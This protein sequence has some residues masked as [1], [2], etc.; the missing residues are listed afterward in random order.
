MYNNLLYAHTYIYIHMITHA[1]TYIIMYICNVQYIQRKN[2]APRMSYGIS[3]RGIQISIQILLKP[4]FKGR[5]TRDA[6]KVAWTSYAKVS[7]GLSYSF[8]RGKLRTFSLLLS[9]NNS[10]VRCLVSRGSNLRRG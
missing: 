10:A 4:F 9:L 3:C 1:Y 5:V 8:R 6:L 7:A 2:P